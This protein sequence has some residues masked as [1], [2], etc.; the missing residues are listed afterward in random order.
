MPDSV[1]VVTQLEVWRLALGQKRPS[2]AAAIE[3]CSAEGGGISA[4]T[5]WRY[6]R[7][8]GGLLALFAGAL[9][10]YFDVS[11]VALLG[12]GPEPGSARWWTWMTPEEIEVEKLHRR[13]MLRAMGVAG[14]AGTAGRLLPVS[15]LVANAQELGGRGRIGPAE[16]SD[17]QRTATDLA[18]AYAAAPNADAVRAAKAHAYTLL[19]LL[20]PNSATM[21]L[22]T[23][24]CLQ[25]VASDAAALAG[26]G[27][28]NAGRLNEADD[29]FTCALDLAREAGDRRLEALA[30]AAHAWTPLYR[31]AANR[32]PAIAALEAAAEFQPL[33]RPAGRAY[34]FGTLARERAASGEDLI[35]GRFLQEARLAAAL[36]PHDEPG[37]G[38][39]SMHGEL[40]GWDGPTR[41]KVYT[42]S[43]LL[44]LGRP[45][46]ALH[47]FGSALDGT[48]MPVRRSHLHKWI[49]DACV[50][51]G[52]PD[53][54]CASAIAA[55]DEGQSQGVGVIVG[56]V[57]KARATFPRAWENSNPVHWL[58]ERL[59]LA[60]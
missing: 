4:K 23:R 10:K 22:A 14:L 9:R 43:R 52:D 42:G 35:S 18:I 28:M 21:G 17:A 31:S 53:Q 6:E 8:L 55:L 29:W 5:L 30:L 38:W 48:T 60:S 37:W 16:V 50:A 25:S 49:M 27:D 15:D 47:L 11:S 19:E 13:K 32:G 33:L 12:L 7:R 54:A 46:D 20:K 2:M 26:Y 34:V 56:Q 41:P 39:W 1:R 24:A 58:D 40:A 45:S 51:L 44:A 57:H 59:A 36:I 3:A